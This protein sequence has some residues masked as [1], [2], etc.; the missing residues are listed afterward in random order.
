[1]VAGF[2]DQL[3]LCGRL[4]A[5]VLAA[6]PPGPLDVFDD[7][8]DVFGAEMLAYHR[9]FDGARERYRSSI[10]EF[11]ER[12]ERRAL[13]AE[14]YVAAQGRRRELTARWEDWFAAERIDALLEPTVPEVAR[15]RGPGY[16]HAGTDLALI[17][18]TYYWDWLGVPVVAL[19]AGV[20]R[21]SGLPVGVSL[22]APAGHDWA[23]LELGIALQAELGVPSPYRTGGPP[24][25][26]V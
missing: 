1:V 10:R 3:G 18:L 26:V 23:L 8:F 13:P 9:R 24:K 17:S 11:V 7:Y 20:G 2:E 19:P 16:E 5:D 14:E 6:D 12:A 15:L 25:S 22:V 4:G 21:T